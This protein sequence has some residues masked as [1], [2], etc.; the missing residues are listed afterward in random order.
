VKSLDFT[1]CELKRKLKP[2]F[3]GSSGKEIAALRAAHGEDFVTEVHERKI[4]GYSGD[5]PA[6]EPACW[7]GVEVLMHEATFLIAG[8]SRGAH[9]DLPQVLAAA[10]KLELKAL[11]LTHFSARYAHD[12]IRA[13]VRT[14]AAEHALPFPIFAILP[15]EMLVDVFATQPVWPAAAAMPPPSL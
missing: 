9:A 4:L 12:E 6:L 15:G 5:S 2:Q 14:H 10:R 7:K 3:A 8:E 13:A 11:V 1:L